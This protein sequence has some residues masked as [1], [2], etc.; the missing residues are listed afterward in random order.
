[1]SI[2]R[3]YKNHTLRKLKG[4]IFIKKNESFHGK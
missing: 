4:L 1:M 3:N 2:Q